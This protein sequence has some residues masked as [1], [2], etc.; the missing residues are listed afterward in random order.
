MAKHRDFNETL[1]YTVGVVVSIKTKS[2]LCKNAFGKS[3]KGM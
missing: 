3:S 1:Y 2:K